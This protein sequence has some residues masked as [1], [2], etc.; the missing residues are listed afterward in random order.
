M[1][2]LDWDKVMKDLDTY[3][4]GGSA[5]GLGSSLHVQSVIGECLYCLADI[6]CCSVIP[7]FVGL[8]DDGSEVMWHV[9]CG[10]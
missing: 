3:L 8:L 2:Q 7:V 1:K 5:I 9:G 6:Y 10:G 4:I